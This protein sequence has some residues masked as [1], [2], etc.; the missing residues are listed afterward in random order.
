MLGHR[1]SGIV[2]VYDTH[3][4]ESERREAL[5]RWSRRVAEIVNPL[6]PE[7]D[8]VVRLLPA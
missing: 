7:T 5:E 3:R 8:K 6:S 4:F 2:G 1:Q